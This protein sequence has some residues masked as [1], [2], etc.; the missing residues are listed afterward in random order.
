MADKDYTG[1]IILGG[2]GVGVYLAYQYATNNCPGSSSTFCNFWNSTFGGGS[3]AL[4]P[5]TTPPTTPTGTGTQTPTQTAPT[6]SAPPVQSQP[7]P[8]PPQPVSSTPPPVTNPPS[9]TNILTLQDIA[10][11]QYTANISPAQMQAL[12]QQFD[13]ELQ[14]GQI[15]TILGTSVAAYMLGWGGGKTGQTQSVYGITYKFD[16]RNWNLWSL[17]AGL[18]GLGRAGMKLIRGGRKAG[19]LR[20][21]GEQFPGGIDNN[22]GDLAYGFFFTD[23]ST[24]GM[25]AIGDERFAGSRVPRRLV[26]GG[27]RYKIGA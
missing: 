4:P 18:Q 3:A 2:I 10:T 13:Q 7:Q 27:P 9:P 15:K 22:T 20:G 19:N 26:H 24:P 21:L 25:G 17:P 5:S 12:N 11:F 6:T 14:S 16:G 23:G 8:T 1:L